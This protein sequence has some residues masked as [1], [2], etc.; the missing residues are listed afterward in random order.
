[1]TAPVPSDAAPLTSSSDFTLRIQPLEITYIGFAIAAFLLGALLWTLTVRRQEQAK[2]QADTATLQQMLQQTQQ[3]QIATETELRLLQQRLDSEVKAARE[4]LAQREQRLDQLQAVESGL[5]AEVAS[6]KSTLELS[7]RS[8]AEKLQLLADAKQ[9]LTREFELLAGKIFE[10]KQERFSKQSKENLEGTL[11]P[12][13]EQLTE[14]RKRV[15]DVYDRETRDRMSLR[16]E[17]GHLKEL[18]LRMN[19]E[20]LK[21]TRALKG[22]TKTQGN[23]GEVILERVLEESGLRK[24]HE[25]ETQLAMRDD[26]G[27]RRY[28]DVVVRLP[29]NKD[30]VIDAKVSLV[31]YERYCNAVEEAERQSALREHIA[32]MRAH[33]GGLSA[34]DY[35]NLEG[36]RSLDFVLIFV[37]IEAAFLTAFDA[38]PALFRD[39][40]E[41]NILV[42]S[43]TTLLVTLRTV[44]T[45]WRYERQNVNAERIAKEAGS[46]HDQFALVLDALEGMGKH[47]DKSREQY[48]L[49]FNRFA[50]GKGNLVKRVGDLA[51]LGA[52]TKKSLPENLL[53]AADDETELLG[54]DERVDRAADSAEPSA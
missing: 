32:S 7:E 21:L 25:Y 2:A 50:R 23:W 37:P 19:D 17:L 53:A 8:A 30:I 14:F 4:S 52:K 34:K 5:R 51:K 3:N 49:T 10:E 26:S 48:E 31:N 41:K 9:Q 28:P 27:K 42:V 1:M 16:T 45:I 22:E 54:A 33:I 6:L 39:A 46:I 11:N 20:A 15:D 47:L 43:P 35:E 29:D 40:Y 13:R 44:Q 36:V 24:G 38:D 12:L 18:N